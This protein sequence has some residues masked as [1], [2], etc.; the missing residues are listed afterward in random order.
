MCSDA[1]GPG[2]LRLELYLESKQVM[3]GYYLCT[4]VEWL[5]NLMPN[6]DKDPMGNVHFMRFSS[7]EVELEA[8]IGQGSKS[9]ELAMATSFQMATGNSYCDGDESWNPQCFLADVSL[10]LALVV[11]GTPCSD[12]RS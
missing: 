2:Q 1:S 7:F 3:G 12:P 8:N 10:S 6:G 9:L 11:E 4:G 5:V